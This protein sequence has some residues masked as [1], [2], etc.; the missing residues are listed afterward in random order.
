MRRSLGPNFPLSAKP[1]SSHLIWVAVLAGLAGC[2]SVSDTLA[3]GKVDYR[4]GSVKTAALDVPPDLTQLSSDPRYQPPSGAPVSANAVQAAG[5]AVNRGGIAAATNQIAPLQQGSVRIERADN[6]RWLVTTL[7]PEQLWPKLRDFWQANGFTL[8]DDKPDLGV[9]ETDWKENRAKLPQ[10][11]IRRTIGQVLD[12]LYDSG[13]RDRYRTR[14]ERGANGTEIYISHRGAEEVY[15][16][17]NTSNVQT[18]WQMRPSDPGLEAEMLGRLMARLTTSETATKAEA[19]NATAQAVKDV[20]AAP[21]SA[22][23]ARVIEGGTASSL[24]MDDGF[25][26]AWRRVGNALDRTG[27]TVEDRD[28]S[29][30]MFYVRYVDP[31]LAGKKDPGFFD[32]LF[33][34]KKE[35]LA[36][37]RYRIVVRGAPQG[38]SSTVI[39]QDAQG[40]PLKDGNSDNII[41]L[42]LTELR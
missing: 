42:L 13:E 2:S 17:R 21:T 33:G 15:T 26:R 31:K 35:E 11:I 39:V 1:H 14:V 12:G 32:R 37:E 5:S 30:G 22:P 24:Q 25:E 40:K 41:K 36:G 8:V 38:S 28:R 10:D 34:A 23:K 3:P 4:A 6:T 19:N 9:M 18:A 27:F 16:E 7:T 29:Q 20:N